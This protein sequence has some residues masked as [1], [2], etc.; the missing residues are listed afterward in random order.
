MVIYADAKRE[1]VPSLVKGFLRYRLRQ[2]KRRNNVLE[3]KY[4]LL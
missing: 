1:S 3:A 2:A 4:I